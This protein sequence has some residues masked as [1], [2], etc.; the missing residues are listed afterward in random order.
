MLPLA[1][2]AADFATA[3]NVSSRRVVRALPVALAPA[4]SGAQQRQEA[5]PG[6][7]LPVPTKPAT[8]SVLASQ[9]RGEGAVPVAQAPVDVPV[10]RERRRRS[11]GV[12][13][14]ILA[15]AEGQPDPRVSSAA[16]ASP[17]IAA[18]I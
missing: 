1:R 18:G 8:P 14:N 9:A 11:A 5:V 12:G 3:H 7:S 13:P 2:L 4:E 6:S 15:G 10:S 17:V 16:S